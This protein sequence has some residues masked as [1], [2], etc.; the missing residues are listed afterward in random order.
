MLAQQEEK[1]DELSSSSSAMIS[2]ELSDGRLYDPSVPTTSDNDQY[3]E[4]QLDD[5]AGFPSNTVE[6]EKVSQLIG[7]H[8]EVLNTW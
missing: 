3:V 5:L 4:F 6:E 7:Y 8:I 1:C 2:F